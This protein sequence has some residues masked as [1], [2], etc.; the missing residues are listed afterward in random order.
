[1]QVVFWRWLV[2]LSFTGWGL[3]KRFHEACKV[4]GGLGSYV[5]RACAAAAASVMD[6]GQ[7]LPCTWTSHVL[8]VRPHVCLSLSGFLRSTGSGPKTVPFLSAGN[9]RGEREKTRPDWLGS[10]LQFG[11]I[12]SVEGM[13]F[14]PVLCW[15][16]VGKCPDGTVLWFLFRGVSASQQPLFTIE[17]LREEDSKDPEDGRVW[18][19]CSWVT[20]LPWWSLI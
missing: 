9:W 7:S 15:R 12:S 14:A 20:N 3:D 4:K 10:F 1:M 6:V 16:W 13:G 17:I 2:F 18:D 5:H 19:T 11:F 8:F